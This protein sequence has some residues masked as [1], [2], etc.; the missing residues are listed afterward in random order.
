MTLHIVRCYPE[1]FGHNLRRAWESH[2]TSMPAR[3]EL[4]FKP[5]PFKGLTPLQQFEKMEMGDLWED[6]RLWEPL[7]YMMTS[8]RCRKGLNSFSSKLPVCL[9]YACAGV[10]LF[11]TAGH[12]SPCGRIPEMWQSAIQTFWKEYQEQACKILSWPYFQTVLFYHW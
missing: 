9:E 11:K 2:V 4:R 1:G 12:C 10:V 6:A 7:Q 3:R 5:Q 8:N